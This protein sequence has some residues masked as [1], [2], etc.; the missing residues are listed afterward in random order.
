VPEFFNVSCVRDASFPE[1]KPLVLELFREYENS[2]SLDLSFQDFEAEVAGLPGK[3]APPQG[4]LLLADDLGCI[5]MRSLEPDI[6]EMKRLYV[7]KKARGRGVGRAL[8]AAILDRARTTGYRAM[9]LDTMPTMGSA[10][11]IYRALGFRDIPQYCANPVP[12][13]LFLELVL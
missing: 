1:D 11:Q 7:R 8:V 2:L 3:Y 13:A 12:G 10:I 4:A 5:A 9:R 6:C